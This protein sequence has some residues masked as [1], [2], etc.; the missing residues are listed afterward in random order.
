MNYPN[1]VNNS[2]NVGRYTV[3]WLDVA[4]LVTTAV[5]LVALNL[6]LRRT[7][8]GIGIRAAASDFRTTA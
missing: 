7:V 2:F 4:T 1:W 5:V 3:Q 8:T 6:F